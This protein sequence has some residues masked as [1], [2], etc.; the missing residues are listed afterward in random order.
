MAESGPQGLRRILK[1]SRYSWQGPRAACRNEAAF[2]EEAWL[3][4]LLA[5]LGLYLGETGAE[6]ALLVTSALL[7]L[8]VKI[9]CHAIESVVGRFGG[10]W[11]EL[12]GRAKDRGSVAV[13][14]ARV[15]LAVVWSLV[16]FGW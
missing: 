9:L 11:N 14:L 12:S 16:L 8:L 6:K 4:L 3:C 1:A 2:R 5:P 13:A 10:E 7:V 15:L